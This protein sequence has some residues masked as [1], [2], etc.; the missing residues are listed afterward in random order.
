MS[1]FQSFILFGVGFE[2]HY[3]SNERVLLLAP[4]L[5]SKSR[6]SWRNWNQVGTSMIF[7]VHFKEVPWE[8]FHFWMIYVEFWQVSLSLRSF[9]CLS[10]F[11]CF[12]MLEVI[13][14]DI[15]I[16][17]I[18]KCSKLK[19]FI[20]INLECQKNHRIYICKPCDKFYHLN[21]CILFLHLRR[22]CNS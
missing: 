14:Q 15:L 16:L 17:Q 3:Y 5:P 9:F 19:K 4:W 1:T 10:F 8:D 12:D 22:T 21:N 18:Y 20:R 2:H 11:F 6:F 7:K 13:F